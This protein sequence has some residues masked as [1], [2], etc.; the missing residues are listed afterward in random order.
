MEPPPEFIGRAIE[1]RALLAKKSYFLF[2]PR[3]PGK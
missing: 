2:G 1:L 3:Q